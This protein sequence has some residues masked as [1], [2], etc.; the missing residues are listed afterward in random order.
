[1]DPDAF[2]G[3]LS[4]H[5]SDKRRAV[6]DAALRRLGSTSGDEELELDLV[7]ARVWRLTRE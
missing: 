2:V 5:M 3:W 1:M 7:S 4:G 6:V